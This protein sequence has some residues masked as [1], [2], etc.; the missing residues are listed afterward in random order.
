MLIICHC[1]LSRTYNGP[2]TARMFL[3][4]SA[5]LNDVACMISFRFQLTRSIGPTNATLYKARSMCAL[6]FKQ[7]D[8]Q[9]CFQSGFCRRGRVLA[10]RFQES[11]SSWNSS[12]SIKTPE[13]SPHSSIYPDVKFVFDIIMHEESIVHVRIDEEDGLRKQEKAKAV[14]GPKTDMELIVDFNSLKITLYRGGIE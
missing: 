1:S 14:Y 5:A 2:A 9:T 6:A 3:F 7:S 8:F 10:A 12:Y 13:P 4:H 11:P